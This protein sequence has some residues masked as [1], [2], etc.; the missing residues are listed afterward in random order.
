MR[1]S[2]LYIISGPSGVGKS[3]TINLLLAKEN[4][5]SRVVTHTTRQKRPDEING[6]SYHFI[7]H[8]VFMSMLHENKF[9][10]Y[11]EAYGNYY[12]LTAE[13][14]IDN[15]NP[16]NDTIIDL[17]PEQTRIIKKKVKTPTVSIFL[18]PESINQLKARIKTRLGEHKYEEERLS[19]AHSMVAVYPEYDFILVNRYQKIV[20]TVNQLMSIIHVS[21]LRPENFE[22]RETK[23]IHEFGMG[24]IM[25]KIS[26]IIEKIGFDS[27]SKIT[28]EQISGGW[29]NL[30][31]QVNVN[32]KYF[33]VRVTR[34]GS[35]NLIDR[36]DEHRNMLI[37]SR[38]GFYPNCLYFDN[39]SGTYLAKYI[40][41]DGHLLPETMVDENNLKKAAELLHK[42]HS[43]KTKFTNERD[44]QIF[45]LMIFNAI[46]Q[47]QKNQIKKDYENTLHAIIA[48]YNKLR[49]TCEKVVNCH[50]ET[51]PRNFLTIG[52]QLMLSDWEYT[53][54]HD[55]SWDLAALSV[56]SNLD[57]SHD[58]KLCNYYG[59]E[60]NIERVNSYKPIVL[61][62]LSLWCIYQIHIKNN[63]TSA[64]VF[65]QKSQLLYTNSI[66]M[67]NDRSYLQMFSVVEAQYFI[68]RGNLTLFSHKQLVKGD[69]EAEYDSDVNLLKI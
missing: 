64:T 14:L 48:I 42:F 8:D 16:N 9:L 66:L 1:N 39:S 15:K 52:N 57:Y 30:S 49:R 36:Q 18:M 68:K 19:V 44:I 35:N 13:S 4:N 55:P 46:P 29:A 7:P 41:N 5:I 65:M 21:R 69:E 67:I 40:V 50:N 6:I 62:W 22:S 23:L 28:I 61:Y 34:K 37:V 60:T 63:A 43:V 17:T 27:R 26:G 59:R 51:S 45:L 12:G 33:F 38:E 24:Q 32:G 58:T 2:I 56:E 3:S 53:G 54:L 10:S 20:D 31:Y 25:H 11:F 47:N